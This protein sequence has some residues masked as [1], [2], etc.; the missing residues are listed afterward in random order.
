MGW[1]GTLGRENPLHI[2]A[3][4]DGSLGQEKRQQVISDGIVARN[5]VCSS[6]DD[7]HDMLMRM[8]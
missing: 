5:A 6:S 8:R 4:M 1:P 7:G 2:D 3:K